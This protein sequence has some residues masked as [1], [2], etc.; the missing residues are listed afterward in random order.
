MS[1]FPKMV[2]PKIVHSNLRKINLNQYSKAR[3]ESVIFLFVY[4]QETS[5]DL[6]QVQV[7]LKYI[8]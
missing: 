1:D 5:L 6:K 3:D 2:I 7:W 4:I 8:H